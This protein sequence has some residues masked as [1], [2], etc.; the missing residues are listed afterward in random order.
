MILLH[1]GPRLFVPLLCEL[2]GGYNYEQKMA[3]M[4]GIPEL[5]LQNLTI[6][7]RKNVS[8][9]ALLSACSK[10]CHTDVAVSTERHVL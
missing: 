1:R 2:K 4:E 10:H 6:A 8:I 5:V 9:A 7:E 3:A